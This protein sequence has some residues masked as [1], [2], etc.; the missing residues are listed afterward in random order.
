MTSSYSVVTPHVLGNF[1]SETIECSVDQLCGLA[2][3]YCRSSR[4]SETG[5]ATAVGRAPGESGAFQGHAGGV[6]V[7]TGQIAYEWETMW[8]S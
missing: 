6:P 4:K 2:C 1:L 3:G 7:S 5:K 8:C